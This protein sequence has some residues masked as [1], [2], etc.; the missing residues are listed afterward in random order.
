M[1]RRAKFDPDGIFAALVSHEVDFV[2]I[3]GLAGVAQGAPWPTMDAD[4][5]VAA[6]DDNLVRLDGALRELAAEYD[7]PHQPPIQP[8]LRLLR[9]SSGPQL[10]RTARGRLD[11]LKEAGGETYETLTR[12]AAALEVHGVVL[13]CASLRALLRMK[14]AANRP[15]D[16]HAITLIE[17]AL[18]RERGE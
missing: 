2:L 16:Q 6:D 11:V 13:H 15:K 3:G 18:R 10:F 4:V 8:D 9:S 5:V 17:D 14:R 12:D 1:T 7:T